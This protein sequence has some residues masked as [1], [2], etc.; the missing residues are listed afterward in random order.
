[1]VNMKAFVITDIH[2]YYGLMM[3]ALKRSGFEED[4]PEHII[5][6]CG[7]LLDRGQ[8]ARECLEFINKMISQNRA[9]LVCGNHEALL[10]RLLNGGNVMSYDHSNGT[11]GTMRQIA[12]ATKKAPYNEI[13]HA[14]RD[15]YN[16]NNYLDYLDYYYETKDYIFVHGWLPLDTNFRKPI[17]N[18]YKTWKD[19]MWYNGIKH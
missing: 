18:D 10:M 17:P 5:I 14:C 11:I 9:H 6:S 16:L 4:N 7:D 2:N 19:A 8:K 13:L 1:M 15:D 12:Q 3:Q